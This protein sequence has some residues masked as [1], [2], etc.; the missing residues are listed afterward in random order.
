[1]FLTASLDSVAYSSLWAGEIKGKL[2]IEKK[3]KK[4]NLKRMERQIHITADWKVMT[5]TK[6]KLT[7][8]N[9]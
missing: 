9:N 4:S 8:S 5:G 7:A 6:V 2:N 3:K 1:M